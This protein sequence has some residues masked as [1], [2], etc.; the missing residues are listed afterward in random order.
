MKLPRALLALAIL[1]AG[2]PPSVLLYAANEDGSL[3]N[4]G[5]WRQLSMAALVAASSFLITRG[6]W[7][8]ELR[9]VVVGVLLTYGLWLGF[10]MAVDPSSLM[11]LAVIVIFGIP[12]TAPIMV[13]AWFASGLLLPL[14]ES[15]QAGE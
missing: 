12:F 7:P 4:W 11:W 13:G 15:E 3:W 5:L 1:A 2:V 9:S 10:L 6:A 14:F 8:D